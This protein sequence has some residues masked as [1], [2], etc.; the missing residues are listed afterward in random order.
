VVAQKKLQGRFAGIAHAVGA[1]FD[2]HA[3]F[4]KRGAGTQ[5]FGDPFYFHYAQPAGAV[6]LNSIVMAEGRYIDAFFPRYIQNGL[7]IEPG[8]LAPVYI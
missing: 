6:Y 4:R 5:Q 8:Y 2:Y 1:C 7:P 3:V